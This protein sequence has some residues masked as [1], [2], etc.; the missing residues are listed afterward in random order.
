MAAANQTAA[1]AA[2]VR[3]IGAVVLFSSVMLAQ[4]VNS[5]APLT[6]DKYTVSGTVVNAVTGEPIRH[7]L[8]T[9]QEGAVL[10]DQTG[11]FE[12]PAVAPGTYWPSVRKPGFFSRDELGKPRQLLH[13]RTADDAAGIV[14]QLTPEAVIYGQVVD[15]NGEPVERVPIRLEMSRVQ[16]GLRRRVEL[17]SKTTDSDGAYRIANLRPGTYY[18]CAG[19]LPAPRNRGAAVL[20]SY[21]VSCYEGAMDVS[22]AAAFK[23]TAGQ[24]MEMN[25]SVREQK[26]FRVSGSMSGGANLNCSVQLA[27]AADPTWTI[28]G[29]VKEGSTAFEFPQVPLGTYRLEANCQAPVIGGQLIGSP[30]PLWFGVQTVVV[31]SDMSGITLALSPELSIPISVEAEGAK[32]G[33][34]AIP[35]VRARSVNPLGDDG[36]TTTS[37]DGTPAF[38]RVRPGRYWLDVPIRGGWYVASARWQGADVLHGEMEVQDGQTGTLEITAR[39]DAGQL[40]M[41]FSGAERESSV[42]L[43]IYAD[44]LLGRAPQIMQFGGNK[45][46]MLIPPGSYS[47]LAFDTLDGLQYANPEVMSEYMAHAAHVTLA[48]NGQASVLLD[49]ITR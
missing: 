31:S 21:G 22:G 43:L 39:N 14:L 13:I 19:P 5:P 42:D 17:N 15:K 36:A 49:V 16:Q 26:F 12:F 23:V 27:S 18:L 24:Q 4:I 6:S 38:M 29:E 48:P 8:V 28:G 35:W 33:E 7:A 45:G 41:S 30:S 3:V 10:T 40:A 2:A 20:P 9:F 46:W 37:A 32:P 11:H 25:F 44:E 34:R 47:I 1:R